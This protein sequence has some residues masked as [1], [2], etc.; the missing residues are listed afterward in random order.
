MATVFCTI[1][2]GQQPQRD[3]QLYI[4]RGAR[5]GAR[6]WISAT[7]LA[8]AGKSRISNLKK[9]C[10]NEASPVPLRKLFKLL[11]L[12][13]LEATVAVHLQTRME[14][15]A[16]TDVRRCSQHCVEQSVEPHRT[17]IASDTW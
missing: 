4:E 14:G 16:S 6:D 10:G 13:V 3:V 2:K 9:R 1:A 12:G 11:K 7:R 17:S 8:E 5:V 15:L